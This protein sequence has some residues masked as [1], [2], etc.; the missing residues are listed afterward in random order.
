MADDLESITRR[1]G[2]HIKDLE[3]T[4]ARAHEQL[5]TIKEMLAGGNPVGVARDL[6]A[7]S[8]RAKYGEPYTWSYAKDSAQIKR[9]LRAMG[10]EDLHARMLAY[11]STSEPFIDRQRHSFGLF[12]STVNSYSAR[13]RR[14]DA[15]PAGCQH[16]PR[17][18]SDVEHTRKRGTERQA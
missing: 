10:A 11:L 9:L 15:P 6:F 14:E 5:R 3:A 13:G 1:L 2:P 8:W 17:C 18:S 16:T 7:D 4:I 12:A